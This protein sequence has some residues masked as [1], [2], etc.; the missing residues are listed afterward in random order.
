MIERQELYGIKHYDYGEAYY[1][2]DN[3]MRFRVSRDPLENVI[4]KSEDEKKAQNPK[5]VAEVWF[6]DK[7]YDKAQKEG[8]TKKEFEY[9]DEGSSE[10]ITWLNENRE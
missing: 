8:I 5:L 2:S 1:G 9:S 7:A 4:F 6:E 10:M 3:G